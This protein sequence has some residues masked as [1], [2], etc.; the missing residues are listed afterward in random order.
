M[1]TDGSEKGDNDVENNASGK[2]LQKTGERPSDPSHGNKV[3]A[4]FQCFVCGAVFTTDQ[5]RKQHLEK[6]AH[7]VL[8]E[9]ST[10]EDTETAERQEELN[11]SHDHRI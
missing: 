4:D 2:D 3:A 1:T 5:D 8:H 6:E 10:E 9:D 7:G 11:E